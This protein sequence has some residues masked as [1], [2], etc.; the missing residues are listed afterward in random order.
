MGFPSM[1]VANLGTKAGVLLVGTVFAAAGWLVTHTV[2]NVVSVPTVEYDIDV[3]EK[4]S[5]RVAVTVRNL[6]QDH[7]FSELEFLL[8]LPVGGSGKFKKGAVDPIP[9][10]YSE[11]EITERN[12]FDISYP[13]I[14]LHPGTS[15]RLTASYSGDT[16]PT[17]HIEPAG[18][19]AVRLLAKGYLTWIIRN[20]VEVLFGFFVAWAAIVIIALG[21]MTGGGGNED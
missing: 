21:K 12:D 1:V 5:G 16:I 8:R 6:S 20:E 10:A 9:P 15:L 3:S 13:A 17:F 4:D 2:E 11:R 19:E 14:G 18:E 7:K